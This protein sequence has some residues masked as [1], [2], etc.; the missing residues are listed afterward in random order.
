MMQ[1]ALWGSTPAPW[2]VGYEFVRQMSVGFAV[3]FGPRRA[4][5]PHTQG[6]VQLEQ[7]EQASEETVSEFEMSL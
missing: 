1:I 3:T 7:S 6:N 4:P 2:Y 5:A